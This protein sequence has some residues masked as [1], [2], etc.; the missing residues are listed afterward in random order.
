MYEY[1]T[2]SL[3]RLAVSR[4]GPCMKTN[5]G[6]NVC[7]LTTR[8]A[9]SAGIYAGYQGFLYGPPIAGSD[10]YSSFGWRGARTVWAGWS[11]GISVT[12][13]AALFL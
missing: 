9:P 7:A 10:I 13:M 12:I 1:L 6:G 8:T 2:V 5:N 3:T 4:V 11:D